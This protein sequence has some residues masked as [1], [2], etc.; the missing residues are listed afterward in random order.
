MSLFLED[1]GMDCEGRSGKCFII[2][3]KCFG[4]WNI[5]FYNPFGKP[6]K[7]KQ[8]EDE[9]CVETTLFGYL[10]V[11]YAKPEGRKEI[12]KLNDN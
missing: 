10:E 2:Q 3:F 9:D 6:R 12:K 8:Y 1:Y 4:L 11:F 5:I 7:T